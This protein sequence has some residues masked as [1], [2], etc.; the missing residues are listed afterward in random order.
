MS[1]TDR[2]KAADW[3]PEGPVSILVEPQMGE[4]IGAAARAMWNFG[5]RQM[6]IVNPRDGWPNPAAVA[7]ASGAGGLLDEARVF[8][9]TAEAVADLHMVYATTARPREM[10]KNVMT[11]ERAMAHARELV[12]NGKRVGILYGRERT[13]LE[14]DDVVRANAIVTVP[15]NPAFASLNLAQCVLLMSYEWRR[16]HDETPA[17]VLSAGKSEP[18]LSGEVDRMLDH[19]EA[20]LEAANFFWP[21]H[22]KPSMA[23]NLRNLF[24][25]APLTDQDVRTLWGVVRALAEGPRRRG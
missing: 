17:E 15:V 19:L 11:P 7:M 14:N 9:T 3:S 1:G 4:N 5:L 24:R 6:R 13:G 8:A 20:E 25:R 21:A 23:A 18:A 2:T 16:Q 12:A 10:A 22:K